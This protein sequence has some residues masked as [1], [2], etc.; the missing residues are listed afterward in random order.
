MKR[1]AQNLLVSTLLTMPAIAIAHEATLKPTPVIPVRP[2]AGPA[3][4]NATPSDIE[5]SDAET[6]AAAQ[7]VYKDTKGDSENWPAYL[8]DASASAVSAAGILG[9]SGES[10]TTVQTL[11][12]VAVGLKGLSTDGNGATLAVSLTPGRT[13]LS[14]ISL[15]QYVAN[16]FLRFVSNI[17]F[18]YAQGDTEI[19]ST[20]FERR[21]VSV[22]AS[23]LVFARDDLVVSYPALYARKD[24]GCASPTTAIKSPTGAEIG[25]ADV[26][27]PSDGGFQEVPE[28]EQNAADALAAEC[29]RKA[30][31][32]QRWNPSRFSV[33]YGQGW[34]NGQDDADGEESLGR[35]LALSG[36]YGFEGLGKLSDA[37]QLSATYRHTRAE[38]VLESLITGPF[39]K[40]DTTLWVGRLTA[41]SRRFRALVEVSNADKHDVTASQRAFRQALGIDLR[42]RET[43][44]LSLRIGKQRTVDGTDDETGSIFSISYSP[45]ALLK[46]R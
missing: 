16:P 17:T 39:M 5:P 9:I 41:G 15:E 46:L 45:S 34:I 30:V 8:T 13:G 29:Y 26:L 23:H 4:S 44:W 19:S 28:D 24:D 2:L 20:K 18:G 37:L 36:A 27:E 33:A 22:E 40:R 12:D 11:R 38:P 6:D 3:P 35:T 14:P 7:Y 43:L 10:V 42:V 1:T 31:N 25:A 21:A 32:E